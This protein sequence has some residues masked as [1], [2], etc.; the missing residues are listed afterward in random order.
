MPNFDPRQLKIFSQSFT[1]SPA[2]GMQ[3]KNILLEEQARAL[4]DA[5]VEALK[6]VL[7]MP[8]NAPEMQVEAEG[9]EGIWDRLKNAGRRNPQ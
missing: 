4:Q 9:I 8:A 1:A 2:Q 5:K 7:S 6:Q 3:A